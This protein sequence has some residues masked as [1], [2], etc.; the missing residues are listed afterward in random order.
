LT[1]LVACTVLRRLKRGSPA[2][3]QKSVQPVVGYT[4]NRNWCVFCVIS[5]RA[6]VMSLII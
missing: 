3:A 6:V 4:R 5:L 2:V 1:P